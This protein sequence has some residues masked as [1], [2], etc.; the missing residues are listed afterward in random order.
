NPALFARVGLIYLLLMLPFFFGANCIGLTFAAFGR[1]SGRIYR[2]DL[3]GSGLGALAVTIVLFAIRAEDALRLLPLLGALA[4]GLAAWSSTRLATGMLVAAGLAVSLVLPGRWIEPQ[5]SQYKDLA[6]ALD[7]PGAEI[8]TEKT[9]PIGEIAVLRSPQRPLRHAPGLSLES[10]VSPPEQ[11]GL[12]VD[13][14]LA[15][16][17][18][19]YEGDREALA[20]LDYTPRA[21]PYHLLN[22]PRVLLLGLGGGAGMLLATRYH[23]AR[24][25]DAVEIQPAVPRLLREE[26]AEYSGR[27]LAPKSVQAHIGEARA[28]IAARQAQYDLI[29]LPPL[30]SFGAAAGGLGGLQETYAYTLEAFEAYLGHLSEGGILSVTRWL[31]L[32]PRDTLKAAAT[33]IAALERGGVQEPGRHLALVRGWKT[34]TL[35]VKRTPFSRDETAKLRAFARERSFDTA[36]YPDMPRS[37]AN[38]FNVLEEPYFYDGVSALLGP[39]RGRFMERYKFDLEPATDDRPY[40][41]DFTKLGAMPELLSLRTRGGMPLIEWGY[42]VLLATLVQAA[43][44]SCLL[45]L[46]P[47]AAL[48][49]GTH[50]KGARGAVTLYFLLLGLGFFF[51]EIALIKR[52]TLFLGHPLYAVAV[53]LAAFL[54]FAGL[55]SGFTPRLTER[56]RGRRLGA[57]DAVGAAIAGFGLMYILAGPALLN[58]A[59]AWPL[60]VK[61]ALALALQAP[62]AFAMGMPLPLGIA[63]ISEGASELVPLAWGVNGCASVVSTVLA[64]LIAIHAGFTVVV[65]IALALYLLAAL[66]YRRLP[67]GDEGIAQGREAS[68][69]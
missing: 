50:A 35:L 61:I 48:G 16:A 42:I 7:L 19:R 28:F 5:V 4:A 52:L 13:A 32:P 1:S 44:L 62:I 20:Y 6:R 24:Q 10:P 33:A 3:V 55:G 29:Q 15:G 11:L 56:L 41:F 63:R 43:V 46:A 38:R 45:I 30:D 39:E 53:V 26:F 37:E 58:A 67:A 21:A 22:R 66:A 25:V 47:L 2:F 36:Y 27:L 34:T 68:P 60:P 31:R 17:I 65:A 49:G 9:G 59:M 57:L 40:F 64:A 54:V 51:I 23:D 8:V 12:F 69:G 14:N 18:A